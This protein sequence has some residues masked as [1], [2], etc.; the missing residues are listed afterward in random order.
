MRS[1]EWNNLKT[2]PFVLAWTENFSYPEICEYFDVTM[3]MSRL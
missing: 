1:Q 3:I 2:Q